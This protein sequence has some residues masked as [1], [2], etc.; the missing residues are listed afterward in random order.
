[1]SCCKPAKRR[2]ESNWL[3][4]RL[5]AGLQHDIQRKSQQ[6]YPG[7]GNQTMESHLSGRC[8][9]SIWRQNLPESVLESSLS[10]GISSVRNGAA[11]VD[12]GDEGAPCTSETI[13]IHQC[14]SIFACSEALSRV[15]LP[16]PV[17]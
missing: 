4:K 13:P 6:Q 3:P 11:K 12:H 9:F 8:S 2:F 5:F 14:H 10:L 7:G 17:E 16:L 15:T 1:M